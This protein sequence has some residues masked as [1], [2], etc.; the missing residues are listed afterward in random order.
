MS[1][2][3]LF[4]VLV[5]MAA[6]CGGERRTLGLLCIAVGTFALVSAAYPG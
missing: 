4:A 6:L 2:G 5:P 3:S 1:L